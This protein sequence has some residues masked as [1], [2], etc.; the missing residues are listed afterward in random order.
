MTF[1]TTTYNKLT[2]FSEMLLSGHCIPT[3]FLFSEFS[4]KSRLSMNV[5]HFDV[6]G[7]NFIASLI[8]M[9]VWLFKESIFPW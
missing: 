1:T 5:N 2:L 7:R 9:E 3:Q 8:L 6:Q 4:K